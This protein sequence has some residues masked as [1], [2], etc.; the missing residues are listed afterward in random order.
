MKVP[1]SKTALIQLKNELQTIKD[2][3][4]ILQQKRDILLKE[5]LGILDDVESLRKRLNEAVV[6][7]YNLLVKAYM[8]AGKDS[9]LKESRLTNFKGELYVYQKTF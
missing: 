3:R 1:P 6:K 4:D 7:S 9:V 2:G 8:E 5:I